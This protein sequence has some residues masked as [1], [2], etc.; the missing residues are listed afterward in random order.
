VK[1]FLFAIILLSFSVYGESEADLQAFCFEKN[2]NLNAVK[3]SL[4]LL[5]L[6]KDIIAIRPD[7]NCLDIITSPDRG[8]LF[9]KFLSKRYDLKNENKDTR[10]SMASLEKNY[11]RLDFK[12]S[13]TSKEETSRFKIGQLNEVNKKENVVFSSNIM[14]ILLGA[15]HQGEIEADGSKLVVTCQMIEGGELANLVFSF[16]EKSKG[17]LTSLAVV[18]KGDWL[19][20]GSVLKDLNEKNKMLGFPQTDI[21]DTQ[22]KSETKYE[23]QYK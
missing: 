19:N 6:P 18:K 8:K 11:C 17:N 20:V 1:T 15:N 13:T 4:D 3:K 14:E 10:P 7:E 22:I 21:S 23:I 16:A 12:T 2:V 5:I 9:E